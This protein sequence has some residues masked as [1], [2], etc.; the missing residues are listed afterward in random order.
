MGQLTGE[1]ECKLDAKGRMMLPAALKRQLPNVEL[2]GLVVNRGLERHLVL[3]TKNEW[4]KI[5]NRLAKL[6]RYVVKNRQFIRTFTRGH[7][8]LA[9]DSS[10]RVLISKSLLDYAGIDTEVVLLCQI[11]QIEIW[12]KEAYQKLWENEA[13]DDFAQLAEE[14]MGGFEMEDDND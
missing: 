4:D 3:Y 6:N 7:S 2:D 9:L 14:V 11:D 12:S 10:N 13:D 1:F 8:E 5:T